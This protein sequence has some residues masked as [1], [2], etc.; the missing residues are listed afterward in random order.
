LEQ[1]YYLIKHLRTFTIFNFPIIVGISRKSMIQIFLE[2]NSAD[3]LAGT[4]AI[5]TIALC[6]G[7]S[8]L[9]VHD[10]KQGVEIVKLLNLFHSL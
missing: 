7:A 10:V 9:R 8:L 1:N 2:T 4:I 5:N 6:H 3:S